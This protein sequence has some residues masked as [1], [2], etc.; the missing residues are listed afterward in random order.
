MLLNALISRYVADGQPVGSRTLSRE[1]VLDLSP[2]TIR[3]VMADLEDLGLVTSPHTSAGRIP[4]QLG[5]RFFVD[6]IMKVRPLQE[7]MMSDIRGQLDSSLGRDEVL[8]NA[9]EMLSKITQ[10]AGV[11]TLTKQRNIQLRQVEF[12]KLSG[13]RILSILVT[14]DGRVENRVLSSDRVYTESE[15]VE[16]ANCFNDLYSGKTLTDVRECLVRDMKVDNREA[17]RIMKTAVTM[18]QDL[19]D[20]G[21]DGTDDVV[22]RGETNL[23]GVP[24]FTEMG[25][26]KGIF[27][28]FRTKHNLLDLMER[29]IRGD[30]I[31]IF[32]GDESGYEALTDCSVIT[33]PYNIEGE[34][35]GVIGVI[36]PTRMAYEDIVPVVDIT[37]RL[38]GNFLSEDR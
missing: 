3:N 36:G 30:G 13:N 35:V 19:F 21:D 7:D 31:H 29:S 4:T 22:V 5:Y 6:S 27:D 12:L 28:T 37:A 1:S 26:L 33:A 11:V 25:K 23:M 8:Q 34:G 16:A 18:V 24:E 38:M 2:A 17:D 20:N 32:I 15:L 9:S 10:F 14:D